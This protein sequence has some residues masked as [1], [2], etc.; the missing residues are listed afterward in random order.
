MTVF[1]ASRQCDVSPEPVT[2][3]RLVAQARLNETMAEA[4]RPVFGEAAAQRAKRL[5]VRS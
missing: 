4:L 5:V 3:H 2:A 1:R